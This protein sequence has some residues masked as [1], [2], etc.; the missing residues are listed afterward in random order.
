MIMRY[1][2]VL[3]AILLISLLSDYASAQQ[4][5]IQKKGN[6]EIGLG[7]TCFGPGRQ[8]AD[9][10]SKYGFDATSP[11]DWFGD[12]QAHPHYNRVGFS[13]QLSYSRYISHLYQLGL[14]L[15][16]SR[17]SEVMGYSNGGWYLFVR[18]S[19]ISLVP[20]I[21]I[22]LNKYLEGQAGVALMINEGKKTSSGGPIAEKYN[23]I[24]PGLLAGLN[25]KIWNARTT[26][27]KIGT[28]YLLAPGNKMGPYTDYDPVNDVRIPES[29]I[30]FSQMH[31]NFIFG[32]KL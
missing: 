24:S 2:K 8:M 30:R 22:P 26:Y 25:L 11:A 4:D 18:L 21:T 10:M 29:G 12:A 15:N 32:M 28:S 17:L 1:L 16:Y 20:Y 5:T 6:L 13:S 14:M 3:S 31:V 19:S 27:G 23:R 9:L 7:I